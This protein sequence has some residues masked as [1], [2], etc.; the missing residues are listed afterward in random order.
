KTYYVIC[1]SGSRSGRTC[2][3]LTK[4]GYDVVNVTGGYGSYVG[5]KRK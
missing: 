5:S 2:R 1:H 3:Y 4:L